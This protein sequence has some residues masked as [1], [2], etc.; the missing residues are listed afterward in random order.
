MDSPTRTRIGQRLSIL[1]LV[2]T[3][4][5]DHISNVNVGS[6]IGRSDPGTI[7]FNFDLHPITEEGKFKR[8]LYGKVNNKEMNKYLKQAINIYASYDIDC[9]W[10]AINIMKGM[11]DFMP[12]I[13]LH[14]NMVK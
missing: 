1:Y 3:N 5:D 10:H 14:C 11:H 13:D 9:I 4:I 6:A 2:L 7:T 8:Y 12:I